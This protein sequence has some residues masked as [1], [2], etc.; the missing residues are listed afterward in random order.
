[1]TPWLL[2]GIGISAVGT[3]FVLAL[4]T[5]A[6]D[7][8]DAME[9]AETEAIRARLDVDLANHPVYGVAYRQLRALPEVKR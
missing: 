1:M 8:D 9:D 7:A 6:S 5:A 2:A 4:L 3:V